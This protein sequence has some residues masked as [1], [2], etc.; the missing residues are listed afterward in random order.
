[1]PCFPILAYVIPTI[2]APIFV[3]FAYIPRI[4][5]MFSS[6]ILNFTCWFVVQVMVLTLFPL[7]S[8]NEIIAKYNTHSKNLGKEEPPSLDLNV[9]NHSFLYC[10]AR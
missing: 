8:M 4:M 10:N 9:C 3:H 2:K 6:V 1:M 7:D 5:N